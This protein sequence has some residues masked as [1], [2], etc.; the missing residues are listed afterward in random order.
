MWCSTL[1]FV[2]KL[3]PH[4]DKIIIIIIILL[5]NQLGTKLYRFQ[6]QPMISVSQ[7]HFSVSQTKLSEL[8]LAYGMSSFGINCFMRVS[9][10]E[11]TVSKQNDVIPLR[12]SSLLSYLKQK[13]FEGKIV[14]Q[15][16]S[17][18]FLVEWA[19]RAAWDIWHLCQK[20]FIHRAKTDTASREAIARKSQ[21]PERRY[22]EL[23]VKGVYL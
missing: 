23:G 12:Q 15:C 17:R 20:G 2:I 13:K 9:F 14:S 11:Q 5:Q 1:I 18:L 7:A 19:A 10:F 16:L 21:V 6:I 8:Y 22:F 3:L 4:Y